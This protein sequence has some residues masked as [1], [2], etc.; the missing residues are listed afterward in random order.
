MFR[1]SFPFCHSFVDLSGYLL[2]LCLS[3]LSL[4]HAPDNLAKNENTDPML[5]NPFK[6]PP[7]AFV[8]LPVSLLSSCFF[9][10]LFHLI[11]SSFYLI[12]ML[13]RRQ[14]RIQI[15]TCLTLTSPLRPPWPPPHSERPL[16]Y[17]FYQQYELTVKLMDNITNSTRI[18]SDSDSHLSNESDPL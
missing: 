1:L 16:G 14:M 6:P 3:L 2:S 18:R 7:S 4:S 13:L 17:V 10:S 5:L 9:L 15:P 12:L 11:L 8:R